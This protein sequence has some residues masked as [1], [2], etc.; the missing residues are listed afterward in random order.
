M[1]NK[2]LFLDRDGTINVDKGYINDLAV[3]E[4][5]PGT[6]D[7]LHLALENGFIFSMITN[8]AGIGKGLTP[9]DMPE[10]IRKHIEK[11]CEM[12]FSDARVCPHKVEDACECR[13]PGTLNLQ[14]SIEFLNADIKQSLFIG[15][16]TKDMEAAHRMGMRSI[17]VLTGHG[18]S[19]LEELKTMPE[20]KLSYV[21]ENLLDAIKWI[22][23]SK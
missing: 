8:Q 7:A 5:I 19:S 21:A 20:I 13:K 18:R 4:F 23:G 1:G 17:L 6:K 12:K 14:N 9:P 16:H 11:E 22:L 10:R 2:V 15:D 3:F